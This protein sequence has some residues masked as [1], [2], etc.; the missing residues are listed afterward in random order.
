MM[1]FSEK[2]CITRPRMSTA[3]PPMERPLTL[4]PAADPSRTIR[5]EALPAYQA[6]AVFGLAPGWV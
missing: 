1:P 3:V 5:M 2:F 4:A 6:V